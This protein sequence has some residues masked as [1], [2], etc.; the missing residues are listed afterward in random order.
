[1]HIFPALF[2]LYKIKALILANIDANTSMSVK[3]LNQP[4]GFEKPLCIN[5]DVRP[6]CRM[7]VRSGRVIRADNW[8]I[9]SPVASPFTWPLN[10]GH[11]VVCL[12]A[13]SLDTGLPSGLV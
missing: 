12:G 11:I 1:M 2:I 3:G 8:R 4:K 5:K 10:R 6:S 9:V 13:S 7:S